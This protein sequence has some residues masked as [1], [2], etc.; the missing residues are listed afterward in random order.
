MQMYE[1]KT[2]VHCS[3]RYSKRVVLN[4]GSSSS[5]SKSPVEVRAASLPT[6]Y[7]RHA[8]QADFTDASTGPFRVCLAS[9]GT[10]QCLVVGNYAEASGD[11]HRLI[12]RMGSALDFSTG[13]SER[14]LVRLRMLLR[15][16]S[17]A[18]IVVLALLLIVLGL[19][20]CSRC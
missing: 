19:T 15:S 12:R 20:T 7:A 10:L 18:C 1:V 16:K 14:V 8:K 6:E 4:C 11:L 17:I 9:Y 2:I 13:L 3:S 5:G